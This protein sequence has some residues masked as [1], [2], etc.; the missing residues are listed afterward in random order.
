M[1]TRNTASARRS[2]KQKLDCGL[3]V[4]QTIPA[5]RTSGNATVFTERLLPDGRPTGT[6]AVVGDKS[7]FHLNGGFRKVGLPLW[8]LEKKAEKNA[9]AS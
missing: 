6:Y 5:T 8:S 2:E 4:R 9:F 1:E 3:Q 7:Q